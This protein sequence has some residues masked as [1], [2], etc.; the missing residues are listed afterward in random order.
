MMKADIRIHTDGSV[1]L[2]HTDKLLTFLSDSPSAVLVHLNPLNP[3]L[4]VL[5]RDVTLG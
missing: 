3:F 5:V 1:Q 2:G 4:I